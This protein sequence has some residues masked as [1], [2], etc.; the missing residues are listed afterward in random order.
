MHSL[1][2]RKELFLTFLLAIFCAFDVS[3]ALASIWGFT[4][5]DAYISWL[6]ARQL[7]EGNGLQWHTG[8]SR[9][10]GYSNFLWVLIASL[11]I[12][13]KLPV[14]LSIK[15]IS[16]F[17]LGAGLFFLYRLGRL[18]V[19]PLLSILPVFI[20]SHF[21]GVTWWTM[22]GLESMFYCAL[23][24]LF[25]WQCA[26]SFGYQTVEGAQDNQSARVPSTR[27][28]VVTNG[29]LL[30]LSLTRFEGTIWLI[31]ALLFICC[32]LR[33][34][35]QSTFFAQRRTIC[36]W[37]FITFVCF[38]I[39]YTLYFIWRLNYF[40]NWIPN[41][42]LCKTISPGQIF[43]VDFDYLLILMPLIIA[44]LP[45]FLSSKDCRHWLLW[46]P[47]VLYAV[48]LW[49]A[50]PVIAH[51]LRLFLGPMA[52]FSILPVLG[53]IRFLNYFKNKLLDPKLS[54]T[55]IIVLG[56]FLFIP[57]NDPQYLHSLFRQYQ[58]RTQIRMK[59][60][61]VL[62][63]Q[64]AHGDSV[65][66]GD[67]GL[68]PFATRRDI[69]FIDVDCLNNTDLTHAPYKNNLNLYAEYIASQIKP[70]WVITSYNPVTLQG[71]YLFEILRKKN[72]Y[73]DYQLITVLKSGWINDQDLRNPKRTIDYIYKIYK[74]DKK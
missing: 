64:A 24:L 14:I 46:V 49:E 38:V 7:V 51:F 50:N 39:P 30:L 71:N 67:C 44:S 62:N 55:G 3:T 33:S 63:A 10:E 73:D 1:S 16:C 34:Q 69:R 58:E 53:V 11:I 5:D 56:T 21:L 36:I 61:D 31:P 72:F 54:A 70:D 13:L 35:K 52:L 29:V 9:V 15:I 60:V 8:L 65:L 32:Q 45:Y 2:L 28:W 42:Y 74:R 40:G 68:V 43:V 6:Y 66:F 37:A 17:S 26:A 22:S 25:I 27:A 18:F 48:L 23:S 12:K 20:F 19:S 47:S 57:G 59:I 41:S 4:T